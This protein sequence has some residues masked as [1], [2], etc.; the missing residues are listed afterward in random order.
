MKKQLTIALV[1]HDRR[2]ADMV[3]WT[4]EHFEVL[5][6]HHLVCTGT[7]G[8]LIRQAFEEHGINA[9]I[10]CMHSG[11]LGGDAEIAAMVVRKEINLAVFLID[12]LNPQPHEADIQM[13]L[14]QCRVHNVPIACNQYSADLM[15]TSNLWDNAEYVPKIPQYKDF[16]RR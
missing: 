8:S 12:D 9:D 16:V 3:Q 11:P 7:T 15:I 13:L 2:K 5:A 6:K 10:T 4:I 1:A 14:R